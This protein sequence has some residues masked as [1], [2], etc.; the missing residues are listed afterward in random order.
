MLVKGII[1]NY[2]NSY[3]PMDI[4]V[5]VWLSNVQGEMSVESEK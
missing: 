5:L 4:L 2:S 3:F 1:Q